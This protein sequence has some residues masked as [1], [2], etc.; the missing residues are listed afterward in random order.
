MK[1]EPRPRQRLTAK[2]VETISAPAEDRIEIIDTDPGAPRGFM[3]RITS[4]GARSY[5]IESRIR[6]TSKKV[7]ATL[8]RVDEISLADA[9]D[10]GHAIA[11]QA[12]DGVNALEKERAER[13]AK[14]QAITIG[15]LL[16]WHLGE[17]HLG[18]GTRSGHEEKVAMLGRVRIDGQR[19]LEMKAANLTTDDVRRAV[20]SATSAPS[21][22]N[23]ILALVKAAVRRGVAEGKVPLAVTPILHVPRLNPER[24]RS[25]YLS[26][27]EIPKVWSAADASPWSTGPLFAA[28]V[29]FV[30]LTGQRHEETL[31][32]T[33]ADVTFGDA[34]LWMI[35]AKNRKGVGRRDIRR[36]DHDV[37]L[38]SQAVA[39]LERLKA[40]TGND[41]HVFES[42]A[43]NQMGHRIKP[44]RLAAGIPHWTVHDLRRTVETGT[45][46][47]GYSDELVH[48]MTGHRRPGLRGTYNL[49]ER[50]EERRAALQAWAN[51]VEGLLKAADVP[52]LGSAK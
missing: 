47:L 6:R 22:Q 44:V 49:A 30:L 13:R 25:R 39:I 26:S 48:L 18:E 50:R 43:Q 35:A 27:G 20:R 36:Y 11:Q 31:L 34:P 17:S 8:G 15:G 2:N 12:R 19:F 37:P 7:Y 3:L 32:T 51:H 23:R 14:D 41:P 10:K 5:A 4:H 9:R 45:A 42:I 46:E 40:K 29:R 38:P 24:P 52:L 28:F 1:R 33:W 21:H 16:N